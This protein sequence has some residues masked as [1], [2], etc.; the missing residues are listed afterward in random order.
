M[1]E[2]SIAVKISFKY[3]LKIKK[4]L[5]HNWKKGEFIEINNLMKEITKR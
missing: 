4:N 3:L 2:K 5:Y 1:V